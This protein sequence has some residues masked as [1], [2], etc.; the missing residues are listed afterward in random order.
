MLTDEE[1]SASSVPSAMQG[2]VDRLRKFLNDTEATNILTDVEE[3][4]DLELYYALQD[5][6]TQ[7]NYEVEPSSLTFPSIKNLPWN[8][9]RDGGVLNVL[10][11]KGIVSARNV[12]SYNDSGGITVKDQDKYG[13]Y[14]VFYNMLVNRY[15]LA[16]QNFK[17]SKNIDLSYGGS[18]S[19]YDDH[20]Q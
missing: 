15:R 14:T 8:L 3:S 19:E 6:L 17:R 5:V 1:L 16:A 2:R 4:T 10:L 12:L 13:R 9:L 18:H 7:L 20:R 11:S